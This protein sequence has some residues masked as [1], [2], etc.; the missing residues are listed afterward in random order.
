MNN[1][2]VED[3]V[4][5]LSRNTIDGEAVEKTLI[6]ASVKNFKT[7]YDT[8]LDLVGFRRFDVPIRELVRAMKISSTET[9]AH[10]PHRYTYSIPY[11]IVSINNRKVCKESRYYGK[12]VSQETISDNPNIFNFNFLILIDGKFI[13]TGEVV[14][15]DAETVFIL[16]VSAGEDTTMT[17]G[18]PMEDY[19]KYYEANEIVTFMVV[20]NYTFSRAEF[21]RVTFNDV[22]K[23]KIPFS[24]INGPTKFDQ[25]RTLF[26]MNTDTDKSTKRGIFCTVDEENQCI[27]IPDSI[28]VTSTRLSFSAIT[29]QNIHEIKII[30]GGDSCW[31]QLPEEYKLPVPVENIIPFIKDDSVGLVFNH[32]ISLKLYYPNIYKIENWDGTTDLALYIMYNETVDKAYHNDLAILNLLSGNLVDRYENGS[33]PDMVMDYEPQNIEWLTDSDTFAE[34]VYF[35]K[36]SLYNINALSQ[37]V[38]RNPHFLIEYAYL[39]LKSAPKYYINVSK[40]SLDERVRTDTYQECQETG[41]LVFFDEPTYLFS[42]RKKFVGPYGTDFRIFIDNHFICPLD[43]TL[44]LNVDF[45]HFYIPCSLIKSDS[46]IELEKY[47]EYDFKQEVQFN[48]VNQ[49]LTIQIPKHIK[50]I[51]TQDITL[52]DLERGVYLGDAEYKVSAYSDIMESE[53]DLATRGYAT[54]KDSFRVE[55]L[56]DRYVGRKLLVNIY[57]RLS[58]R[59]LHISDIQSPV[60]LSIVNSNRITADKL[61]VYTGGLLLPTNAYSVYDNG[62]YS[63]NAGFILLLDTSSNPEK[64]RTLTVDELPTGQ[65]CEFRLDKI[66]NEYG[67]VDTGDA[68]TLPLDL[69]WY[70]IYV[71]GLKLNKSNVEIITSNKFFIKGID[72]LKNLY[73]YARGDI[74][75]EFDILHEES[76]ENKLFHEIDDIYNDL[77]TDRDIIRDT[78]DDI[79]EDLMKNLIKHLVFVRNILEYSFINANEQQVTE[80][81]RMLYPDLI[82]EYGILWLDSNTFSDAPWVTMINS[83]VRSDYMKNDQYRY[84]WAPLHIGSHDDARAG[85]YMC[86][87]VTGAPGMKGE[88]GSVI[89]TG[90]LDRLNV[91]KTNLQTSLANN[92]LLGLDVYHVQFEENTTAKNITSGE[93]ILDDEITINEVCT[94]AVLSLD[95]Q[96]LKRGYKDVL[97]TS[98]YEPNIEIQYTVVG[99]ERRTVVIPYNDLQETILDVS[100]DGITIHSVIVNPKTEGDDMTQVRCIL[101][102]ILLAI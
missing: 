60:Q 54:I 62:Y 55:L 42:L 28:Q 59:N 39:K 71:N 1:M 19:L 6:S 50:K 18:I 12:A 24:R 93:N 61:R 76:I 91:H 77:L 70:D 36:K 98:C 84:G 80:E 81:I 58:T 53:I 38:L 86:D 44:I 10:Y 21:N 26:F 96:I 32:N 101:H 5:I 47:T 45:Y 2:T 25:E 11:S 9:R 13:D 99:R 27:V 68:L 66:E 4:N 22:L 94:K 95:L 37:I 16:D 97:T 100:G 85:E 78:I 73:I 102:S 69:K 35:P 46:I 87:P 74:Y 49:P 72:S 75:N 90:E 65:I 63:K 29:L 31:F 14:V 34:S 64:Y 23:R 30:S 48:D 15:R 82:D 57:H 33:L 8:Q 20:P 83:N 92:S 52:I 17:D 88:D 56:A 41:E 67:F 79:T 40:L 3:I 51:Y 89:P 7:L 43:Y